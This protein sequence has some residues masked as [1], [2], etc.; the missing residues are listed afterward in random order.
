MTQENSSGSGNLDINIVNVVASASLE[1][2]DRFARYFEG[3]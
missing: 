1:S 2:E 3:V